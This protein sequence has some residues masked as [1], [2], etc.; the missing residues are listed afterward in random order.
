MIG[1]T[2]V[3]ETFVKGIQKFKSQLKTYNYLLWHRNG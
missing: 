3:K 2:Y 1:N